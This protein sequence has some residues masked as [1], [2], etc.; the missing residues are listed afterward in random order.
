MTKHLIIWSIQ[1]DSIFGD[2]PISVELCDPKFNMNNK[3]KSFSLVSFVCPKRNASH[4]WIRQPVSVAQD[5][6]VWRQFVERCVRICRAKR[7]LHDEDLVAVFEVE[8]IAGPGTG[9]PTAVGRGHLLQRHLAIDMTV[10]QH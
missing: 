1:E 6:A 10:W 7:I 9:D 3:N 8:H 5:F 4:G 2:C